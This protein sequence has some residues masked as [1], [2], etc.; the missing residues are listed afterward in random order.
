MNIYRIADSNAKHLIQNVPSHSNVNI[1][2]EYPAFCESVLRRIP[3]I[4]KPL[5]SNLVFL[6]LFIPFMLPYEIKKAVYLDA[7]T[8][9]IDFNAID[10]L[11][12]M[13]YSEPLAAAI[14]PRIK[15][16]VGFN[17]GV[18][19]YN[20]DEYRKI[21]MESIFRTIEHS[22]SNAEDGYVSDENVFYNTGMLIHLFMP[23]YNFWDKLISMDPSLVKIRHNIGSIRHYVNHGG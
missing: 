17:S 5:W 14:Y 18:L 11:Y 13:D 21:G 12:S 19:V 7:D 9:V 2:D 8:E 6:K 20:C 23:I 3:H 22:I 4:D 16:T 10:E 15:Y 1:L